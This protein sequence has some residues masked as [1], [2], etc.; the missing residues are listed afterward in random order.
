MSIPGTSDHVIPVQEAQR[1][2][3]ALLAHVAEHL[4]L[5][6]EQYPREAVDVLL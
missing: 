4:G 6:R 3:E 2:V 5:R 1:V